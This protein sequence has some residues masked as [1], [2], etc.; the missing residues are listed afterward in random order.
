MRLENS[1][2][3]AFRAVVEQ[4]GFRRAAEALHLSQSA[5]S[6]AVAGLEA[7]LG[8]P[9]VQRGKN[10]GLSDA[11]RRVFDH[12]VEVLG[13]EQQT[14]EDIARLRNGARE[15][16][17]LAI[18]GAINYFHAQE[19]ISAYY[20]Q[21]PAVTMHVQELPSRS[22]IYAVLGGQVELGLGPFQK[23][24][25][26]FHTVPLYEDTRHLVV[27][28]RHPAFEAMIAGDA[29]AIRR[30]PL[31]ASALDNPEMRPSIQRLRDQFSAVWE[32][33]SLSLRIH[34]VEQGMGVTFLDRRLL[35]E[36]PRCRELHI[37][38]DLS[39]GRID[40]R[41]G[42]YYRANL[43]LSSAARDFIALCE[44]HWRAG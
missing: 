2:L 29:A 7:K 25:S 34:M 14:L 5:V 27:G 17:S 10:L 40:K 44:A 24:M 13:R 8:L 42:L 41:V 43:A 15:R 30:T 28:P 4:G 20:A 1:E 36:H 19:L 21:N 23:Q 37:M 31:I 9:L 33:S 32:V 3:R 12:A 39:F 35:K 11:G 38:D 26:A 16:L 18:S 22:M 6:Q